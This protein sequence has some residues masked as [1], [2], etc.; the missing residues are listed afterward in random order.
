MVVQPAGGLQLLHE[1][2]DAGQPGA[3]LQQVGRQ[4]GDVALRGMTGLERLAVVPDAIAE[5]A[6]E[7]LPVIAPTQLID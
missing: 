2:I 7:P 1:T 5:L 4:H 6:P 3:G